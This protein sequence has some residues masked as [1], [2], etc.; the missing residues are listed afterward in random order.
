MIN[1]LFESA[2]KE[3]VSLTEQQNRVITESARMLSE[4]SD[5]QIKSI[6]RE[7]DLSPSD[8]ARIFKTAVSVRQEKGIVSKAKDAYVNSAEKIGKISKQ[9]RNKLDSLIKASEPATDKLISLIKNGGKEASEAIDVIDSKV[10][11]QVLK[12]KNVA[13]NYLTSSYNKVIDEINSI[14]KAAKGSPQYGAFAVASLSSAENMMRRQVTTPSIILY[15]TTVSEILKGKKLSS[16][17]QQSMSDIGPAGTASVNESDFEE[18]NRVRELAG[19]DPVNEKFGFGKEKPE[20]SYDELLTTWNRKG[21]PTDIDEIRK[22]LSDAGMSRR[23]I[24]KVFAKA[25]VDSAEGSD[26]KVTRFA[27]ALKKINL[28]DYIIDYL[29]NMHEKDISESVKIDEAEVSDSQIKKVLLQVSRIAGASDKSQEKSVKR[30]LTKWTRE[31]N[32]AP[33]EDKVSIAGEAVNYLHDRQSYEEY[34]DAVNTVTKVIRNS[35]LPQKDKKDLLSNIAN[36]KLYKPRQRVEPEQQ[37][38]EK[39]RARVKPGENGKT[40]VRP[41]NKVES[42]TLDDLQKVFETAIMRNMEKRYGR[43]RRETL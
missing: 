14:E 18:I 35:D 13:R 41:A 15:L 4:L 25:D 36:R 42:M 7:A 19:L 31:F 22:I 40:R 32:N 11:A 24:G 1:N 28:G 3:S 21:R 26:L 38:K 43:K 37:T 17:L 29:E 6:L 16:A 2:A 34:N 8:A 39:P 10:E 23:E 20:L 27:D 5:N 9:V 30:Y 33:D 12:T